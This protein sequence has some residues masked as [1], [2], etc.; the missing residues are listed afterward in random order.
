MVATAPVISSTVSP[1]MRSPI[2]KPP[3][4][5]GVASPD[6][7]LS[8]ACAAS[9]RESCAAVAILPRSARKRS[10]SVA[11]RRVPLRGEIEKILQN[12]LAVLGGDAFRM[13]L[14]AVHRVFLV[15]YRHHQAVVGLGGDFEV[16]WHWIAPYGERVVSG[17]P[18][19]R[20]YTAR[21]TVS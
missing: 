17:R 3:I 5:A 14:H 18:V 21:D 20:D 16:G 10:M 12:G 11:L 7:I 1:R 19:R 9:S 13:E 2:K 8:K 6:I 15:R 4:C